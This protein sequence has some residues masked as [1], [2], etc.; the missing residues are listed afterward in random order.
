MIKVR[1]I[2]CVF[3]ATNMHDFVKILY[4]IK[5]FQENMLIKIFI[6]E[7]IQNN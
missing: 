3:F 6:S 5:Y 7:T 2:L 1:E 4:E